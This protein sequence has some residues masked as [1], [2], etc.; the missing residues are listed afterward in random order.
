MLRIRL[1]RIGK[2][3]KPVYRVVVAPSQNPRSGKFVEVVGHYNPI[4]DP[5]EIRFNEERVLY[6]LGVGA[7]PTET[8]Q[9]LLKLTGIW[10]KFQ[11]SK[12]REA[13]H[14]Q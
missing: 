6:W 5:A 14:A 12:K 1:M 3:K 2:K 10:D 8:V 11:A 4:T 7:Q 9:H 13:A